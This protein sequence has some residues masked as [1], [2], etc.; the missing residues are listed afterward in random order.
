MTNCSALNAFDWCEQGGES[1][2]EPLVAVKFSNAW[3]RKKKCGWRRRRRLIK[4]H[5]ELLSLLLEHF[6]F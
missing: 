1:V 3:F 2:I 4:N 5:V 6:C